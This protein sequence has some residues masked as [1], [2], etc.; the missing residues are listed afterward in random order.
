MNKK[1]FSVLAMVLIVAPFASGQVTPCGQFCTC[2][3]PTICGTF[4]DAACNA[5]TAGSVASADGTSCVM[6]PDAALA[7]PSCSRCSFD[8]FCA[9]CAPGFTMTS[10]LSGTCQQCLVTGCTACDFT[11]LAAGAASNNCLICNAG[12]T[13]NDAG[14]TCVLCDF[15]AIGCSRC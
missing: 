1:W 8:N 2:A 15:V 6:C 10:L 5:M 4:D 7:V 3:F 14:N 12:F 9:E 11:G 13:P